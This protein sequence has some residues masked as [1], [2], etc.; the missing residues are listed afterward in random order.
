MINELKKPA[1]VRESILAG[2]VMLVIC[3]MFYTNFFTPKQ[4]M[5]NEVTVKIEKTDLEIKNTKEINSSLEKK[6]KEQESELKKQAKELANQ[7]E[8]VQLIQKYKTP[9]HNGISDFL[10]A[11]TH[12]NFRTKLSID[13]LKYDPTKKES[14]FTSTQFKLEASGK[15]HN[16]VEFISKLEKVQALVSLDS[17]SIQT[18]DRDSSLI[19]LEIT[20]TFYQLENNN[21]SL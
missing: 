9:D 12:P 10:N 20:G 5:I 14:G 16:A 1:Q 18:S 8:K 13:S 6:H 19:K 4:K 21:E 11:I 3:Y 7:N 2:L 15:F 17:I